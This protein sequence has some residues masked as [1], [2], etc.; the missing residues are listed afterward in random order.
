M[1][2]A[3]IMYAWTPATW[4]TPTAGKVRIGVHPD[5]VGWTRPFASCL[6]AC[7]LSFVEMSDAE[8]ITQMFVAFHAMVVRDGI[9]PQVAHTAFLDIDEYRRAIA[10]DIEGAELY[11]DI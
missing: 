3:E 10:D 4:E 6:G 8:R 2:L 9:D 5:R 1:K 7:D 11:E